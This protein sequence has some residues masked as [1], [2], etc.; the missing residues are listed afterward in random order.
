MS[1]PSLLD[2][3]QLGIYLPNTLPTGIKAG[4]SLK[5]PL[6]ITIFHK[7]GSADRSGPAERPQQWR[8]SRLTRVKNLLEMVTIV[9][10]AQK[11]GG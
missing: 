4:P 3:A 5:A 10:L 6:G 8:G 2:L 9:Y 11:W 7:G 1:S